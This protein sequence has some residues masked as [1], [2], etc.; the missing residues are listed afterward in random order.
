MQYAIV[1][2]EPPCTAFL[3]SAVRLILSKSRLF[4]QGGSV[5]FEDSVIGCLGNDISLA[6]GQIDKFVRRNN[7]LHVTV[8]DT[9]HEHV[10]TAIEMVEMGDVGRQ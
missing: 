5:D 4:G 2:T 10:Q 8:D 7:R 9:I 3:D 1:C 6:N